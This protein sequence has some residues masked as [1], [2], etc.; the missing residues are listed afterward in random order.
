MPDQSTPARAWSLW[1]LI[2]LAL[3]GPP[4]LGI[5]LVGFL[6]HPPSSNGSVPGLVLY[7][8]FAGAFIVMGA[9]RAQPG[10]RQLAFIAI[11]GLN[12]ALWLLILFV[13][14]LAP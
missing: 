12:A 9:T 11:A 8:F 4:I 1:V 7:P 14:M 3:L 6:P 10:N 5:G 2:P 13:G